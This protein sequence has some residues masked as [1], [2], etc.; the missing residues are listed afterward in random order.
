MPATPELAN[1][2]VDLLQHLIRNACV[3]EGVEE[4]GYEVRNADL[5]KTYLEGSGLDEPA[6]FL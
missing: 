6:R 4:S 3:N 1:R 2:T 5:L